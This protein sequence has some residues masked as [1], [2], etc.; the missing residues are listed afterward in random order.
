MARYDSV[1]SVSPEPTEQ[2]LSEDQRNSLEKHSSDDENME[3]E[4]SEGLLA[5]ETRDL[6]KLG[7]LTPAVVGDEGEGRGRKWIIIAAVVLTALMA[8]DAW[9][10]FIPHAKTPSNPP[11]ASVDPHLDALMRVPFRRPGEEYILNPKWDFAA[12]PQVRTYNWTIV[13]K[14]GNPDGVFKPMMMINGQFPGPMME[15]NEGDTVIVNVQNAAKNATGIHWHGL[16]QNGTNFMDGV[17]GVT[18]CPIAPGGSFQYNFTVAGQQG[19]CK[20]SSHT[21]TGRSRSFLLTTDP[22]LLPRSSRSPD[23]ERSCRTPRHPQRERIQN[24]HRSL[25]HRPGHPAAGLVPRPG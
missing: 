24:Q 18:Q 7:P 12:P 10:F 21:N 17:G 13:D 5:A 8:F 11:P 6:E 14:D 9:L 1:R 22:R 20:I 23:V 2:R 3:A 4:Q 25:H 15:V 19:T 16:L